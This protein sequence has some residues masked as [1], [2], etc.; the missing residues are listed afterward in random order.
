[1][2]TEVS[3]SIGEETRSNDGFVCDAIPYT[4]QVPQLVCDVEDDYQ[5]TI[6]YASGTRRTVS[7]YVRTH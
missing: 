5:L 7:F 2:L 6:V 4:L 3:E 1:M